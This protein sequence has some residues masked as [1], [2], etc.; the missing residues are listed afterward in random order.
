VPA[1]ALAA[2]GAYFA[3][4][5][6]V[7]AAEYIPESLARSVYPALSRAATSA[8]GT[9]L[10]PPTRFLITVG[11]PAPAF[12]LI[13]GPW[14][15]GAIFGASVAPYAWIISL[16]GVAVPIRFL[17]ILFGMTLMTG[18]GQRERVV[19]VAVG[20]A[21]TVLLDV[22]LV[23]RVGIVGAPVAAVAAAAVTLLMYVLSISSRIGALDVRAAVVRASISTA[24]AAVPALLLR[25]VSPE[26]AA[27]GFAA[28]YG[29]LVFLPVATLRRRRTEVAPPG[30]G[31]R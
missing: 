31:P 12:L 10:T 1:D 5:R 27:A 24:V 7:A 8:A 6:L 28:T 14:L 25:P 13:A 19:A 2:V 9:M 29:A 15:M 23:P 11:L 18:G 16:L 3:A 17:G 4:L 30:P 22:L 26:L 20:F 21:V